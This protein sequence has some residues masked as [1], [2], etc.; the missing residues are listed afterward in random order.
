MKQLL[1]LVLTLG[2][3]AIVMKFSIPVLKTTLSDVKEEISSE[4]TENYVVTKCSAD[5]SSH[6]VT[7]QKKGGTQKVVFEMKESDFA[8]ADF[9]ENEVI[10]LDIEKTGIMK[11]YSFEGKRL[12]TETERN[13]FKTLVTVLIVVCILVLALICI[14]CPEGFIL[15]CFFDDIFD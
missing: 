11:N 3:F 13:I 8:D 2:I 10:A 4:T 12:Y 15:G 9:T 1:M 5:E 7:M 14:F 6:F